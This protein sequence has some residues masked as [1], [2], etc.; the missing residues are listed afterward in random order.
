MKRVLVLTLFLG[1]TS[2][3][4]AVF[5]QVDGQVGDRFEVGQNATITV[6]GEDTSSWLG[7]IIIEDGSGGLLTGVIRLDAAGNLANVSPYS[8]AGWGTGYELTVSMSPGGIPAIAARPQ[9][10]INFT[11]ALGDNARVSLFLDPDF[12]NPVATVLLSVVPEPMTLLLLGIGSL[13][14]RRWR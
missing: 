9:F 4:N 11:G 2:T 7:Y 3:A 14:L 5:L 12:T 1:L 6:V 13:F 10:T 8:E